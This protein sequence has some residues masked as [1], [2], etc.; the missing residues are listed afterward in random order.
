MGEV[1]QRFV[2]INKL[3]VVSIEKKDSTI[4]VIIPTFG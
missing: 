4:S 3:K 1:R 2:E